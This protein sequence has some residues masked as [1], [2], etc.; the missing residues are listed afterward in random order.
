MNKYLLA[1]CLGALLYF[2]A[3]AQQG[4]PRL[5]LDVPDFHVMTPD[6]K[7]IAHRAGAGLGVAM[8]VGTHWSVARIGLGANVTADLKSDDLQGSILTTPYGLL[9]AGVGKYRSNGDRCAKSHSAAFTAMAKAGL[10]YY[11]DTRKSTPGQELDSKGYGIDYTV[12]AELGYFYI[13]DVFK[14]M[15]VVL[16][17]NYHT[18]AKV[19]SVN[20]GFK[21]F[22]NLKADRPY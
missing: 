16:D 21:L 14:N 10:R 20:F 22:L 2:H 12:G 7:N 4:G 13:R 9:E 1:F 19:I 5:F 15:E 8:N 6:V 18:Q 17:A 3:E 11:L